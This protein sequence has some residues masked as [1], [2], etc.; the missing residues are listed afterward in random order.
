[1]SEITHDI[2][3][4]LS[5]K[6][7]RYIEKMDFVLRELDKKDSQIELLKNEI[8]AI[9]PPDLSFLNRRIDDQEVKIRM[10]T[11]ELEEKDKLIAEVKSN[12]PVIPPIP[13]LGYVTKK[14]EIQENRI[15]GIEQKMLQ[16][17]DKIEEAVNNIK[18]PDISSLLVRLDEQDK[19]IDYISAKIEK[20]NSQSLSLIDSLK[21][22]ISL[23][24][25][26][27]KEFNMATKDEI[28]R[29]I[30]SKDYTT[31]ISVQSDNTEI[32][33]GLNE[34]KKIIQSK[35][36]NDVKDKLS[37][38]ENNI[39]DKITEGVDSLLTE[40]SKKRKWKFM[41][42]KNKDGEITSATAQQI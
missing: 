19:S 2:D 25:E 42:E 9:E 38:L 33:A 6:L 1:M 36:N 12:I 8:A 24:T 34:I 41:P 7:E 13:D 28:I 27:S 18:V 39:G 31:N 3:S 37:E 15:L 32:L 20:K 22:D 23:L 5:R 26:E 10:L 11:L 16:R 17:S 40:V 14:I 30:N 4:R 21:K 29:H 35:N